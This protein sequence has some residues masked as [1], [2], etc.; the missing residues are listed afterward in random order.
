MIGPEVSIEKAHV[1]ASAKYLIHW[2]ETKRLWKKELENKA[3]KA[4]IPL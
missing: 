2:I 3:V 1:V 4:I